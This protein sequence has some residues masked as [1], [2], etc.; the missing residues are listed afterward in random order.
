MPTAKELTPFRFYRNNIS[1]D[2]LAIEPNISGFDKPGC[3]LANHLKYN[4]MFLVLEIRK[5]TKLS[6]C[7]E[8]RPYFEYHILI[9]TACGLY[10]T[11][12]D[13]YFYFGELL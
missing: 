12:P 6:M 10:W 11:R 9:L 4:S 2:W 8:K 1:S 5:T 3:Q 7:K 13:D